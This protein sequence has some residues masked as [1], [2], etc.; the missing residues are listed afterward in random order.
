MIGAY[1]LIFRMKREGGENPPHNGRCCD[2]Q[3]DW[4]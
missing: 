3:S 1:T 2:L 4:I